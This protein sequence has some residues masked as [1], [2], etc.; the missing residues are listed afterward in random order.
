MSQLFSLDFFALRTASYFPTARGAEP[1]LEKQLILAAWIALPPGWFCIEYFLIYKKHAL[2]GSF[3]SFK[4]GQEVAA[5]FWLAGSV[6][7]LGLI[8]RPSRNRS[9][10]QTLVQLTSAHDRSLITIVSCF[11]Q[12]VWI[13]GDLEMDRAAWRRNSFPWDSLRCV[14][15]LLVAG[16]GCSRAKSPKTVD[17]GGLGCFTS[18]MV[19]HRI[20]PD[21]QETCIA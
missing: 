12:D 19:L 1:N 11:L 20:F 5:K 14:W 13:C 16:G 8:P 6:Q 15:P 4:H 3:E 2:P 17:F 18:R 7:S 21:L 10:V 9:T